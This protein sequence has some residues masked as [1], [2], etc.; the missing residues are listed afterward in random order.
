MSSIVQRPLGTL[1]RAPRHNLALF[2]GSLLAY[3]EVWQRAANRLPSGAVLILLPADN[4]VQKHAMLAVAKILG[5][6][7]R[8]VSMQAFR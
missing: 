3:R 1:K 7:G 4:A 5:E 8:Q 6:E 2:P